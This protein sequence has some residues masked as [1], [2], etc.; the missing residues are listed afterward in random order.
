MSRTNCAIGKDVVPASFK[1]VPF[2]CTDADIQ[3]GRRGAEGEFPFSETTAYADLGR[4]IRVYNLTA[5]FR[6]DNHVGDA[7]ALFLAC[8]SPGPGILVHP[9]RGTAMVACRSCKVSDKLEEAGGESTAELE[10]VEANPVG[11][12]LGGLLFGM[13]SSAL[14]TVSRDS[15]VR[16]YQPTRV[17]QP[18][19]ADVIQTAQ[20]LVA[21][22]ATVTKQTLPADAP[23][24]EHRDVLRMEEVASDDGLATT[25]VNVDTALSNG[26]ITIASNV[27]DPDDAFKLMRRLANAGTLVLTLPE[28]IP[29]E[30]AEAVVIR[31]RILAAVGM[32]EAA[33]G[34]KYGYIGEALTTMDMVLAVFDEE[35]Q[36]AYNNCDN[37]LFLEIR[38]YATQF[39]TMMN[40]LAYRLPGLVA[41]DFSGGVHPLVAA[42][43]IY[44][45]ATRHR[46]LETKNRVDANGRFSPLV[47]GIA[48][49]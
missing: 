25:A 37:Q 4:K 20:N 47:I 42:Y 27:T 23:L 21:A 22:V 45:D 35:A 6:E 32:A 29:T 7:S 5:Y 40:D 28:G 1:G 39:A 14:I 24:S 33:M 2:Y 44:N 48:P 13:I 10:F 12:G 17:S 15:F 43:A 38:N 26:F 19:R 11:T 46:E 3:G 9:T 34:R 31:H 36:A 18:W 30:S 41:V 16:D 49:T 8:E